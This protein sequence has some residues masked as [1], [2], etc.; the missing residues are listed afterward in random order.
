MPA[1][2]SSSSSTFGCI[3]SATPISSWRNCPWLSVAGQMR[4]A[5]S[6]RPTRAS[7]DTR[8]RVWTDHRAAAVRHSRRAG[9]ASRAFSS[10][11]ISGIRL[12]RWNERPTP[13]RAMRQALQPVT[14]RPSMRIAAGR[15]REFAGEQIDQRALARAVRTDDRVQLADRKLQRHVRHR[16]QP[17]ERGA[18]RRSPASAAVIA[19]TAIRPDRGAAAAPRAG[20]PGLRPGAGAR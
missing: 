19:R 13:Q 14:S 4:S 3:A 17:A 15:R 10:T 8:R 7:A 12:L 16:E 18:T 9:T 2:G 1:S 11:V 5:T 6:A 20:S